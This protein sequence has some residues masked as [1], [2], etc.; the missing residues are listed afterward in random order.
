MPYLEQNDDGPTVFDTPYGSIVGSAA[1]GRVPDRDI[2]D[3]YLQT[4]PQ[5][6][7][8]KQNETSFQRDLSGSH[9][10]SHGVMP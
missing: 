5:L 4:L 8:T 2:L 3:F 6:G 7:W 1:S 9:S 10:T